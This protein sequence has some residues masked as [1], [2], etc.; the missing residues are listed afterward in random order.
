MQDLGRVNFVVPRQLGIVTPVAYWRDPYKKRG[1]C[2]ATQN[3]GH[4]TS[5]YLF[6]RLNFLQKYVKIVWKIFYFLPSMSEIFENFY[7][8]SMDFQKISSYFRNS[9]RLL[10]ARNRDEFVSRFYVMPLKNCYL[11]WNF[12]YGRNPCYFF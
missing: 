6:F 5:F 7:F 8:H 3:R 12:Y 10:S 11:L 9:F 1:T 4:I 2:L